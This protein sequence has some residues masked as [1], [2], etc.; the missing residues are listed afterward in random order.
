[1]SC[2]FSRRTLAL[3]VEGD[4]PGAATAATLSHLAACEECRCFLEELRAS[5]TL[6]KSVRGERASQSDCTAMRRQVMTIIHEKPE[7]LGWGLRIERA[8]ALGLR[9]SYGLA[10]ILLLGMVSVSV[11]AQ[12]RP[13]ANTLARPDGY[14]D[15]ALVN[16]HGGVD[17]SRAWPSADRIYVMPSSYQAYQKTGMIPEGTVFVWEGAEKAVSGG[18]GPHS[19]SSTLLVSV[20]DSAK[21]EGGWGFFDF[22]GTG[23]AP[24]GKAR[25]L[26]DSKGCRA[27][28]RQSPLSLG[29]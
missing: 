3:H 27:C 15:W 29:A 28:H 9:P 22:S 11:L 26:Q 21:F 25:A 19:S 6:V 17:A 2:G 12:I 18:E 8:I 10:A 23:E 4:L 20:K 7:T 24:S 16:G 5:Q 1:V 14:R 13:A